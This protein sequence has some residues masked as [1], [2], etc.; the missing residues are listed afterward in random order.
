VTELP[1]IIGI[2]REQ[3]RTRPDGSIDLHIELDQRVP[4]HWYEAFAAAFGNRERAV[5]VGRR[6][7]EVALVGG[8]DH[9]GRERTWVRVGGVPANAK[10]L[11][12]ASKAIAPRV[13]EANRIWQE[14]YEE[15]EQRRSAAAASNQRLL[16]MI[17]EAERPSRRVRSSVVLV[18]A[19]VV[20]VALLAWLL[21]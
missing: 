12:R 13:A 7:C 2:D 21:G 3:T 5:M 16:A 18:A 6:Q 19:G 20:L 15:V 9:A 4:P 14:R 1:R 8:R 10:D 17:D 11:Q